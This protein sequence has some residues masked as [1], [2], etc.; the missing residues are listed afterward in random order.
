MAPGVMARALKADRTKARERSQRWDMRVTST[1]ADGNILRLNSHCAQHLLN[2]RNHVRITPYPPL[3]V[4]T[5][6][7]CSKNVAR[8]FHRGTA[9]DRGNV[10]L[11]Q[12]PAKRQV[13]G[14]GDLLYIGSHLQANLLDHGLESGSKL[15]ATHRRIAGR[16]EHHI[17]GHH[18]HLGNK[19]ATARGIAPGIDEG[20]NLLLVW[21]HCFVSFC[22][23]LRTI[24]LVRSSGSTSAAAFGL[25]G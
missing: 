1:R 23:A 3:A 19:I 22:R 14:D 2:D 15:L 17:L 16:E 21:T 5:P 9:S 4:G 6:P 25:A 13:A 12:V 7:K 20:S 18:V 11:K 10:H 24:S 8:P